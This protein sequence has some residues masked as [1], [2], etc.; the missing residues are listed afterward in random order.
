MS[1]SA[2]D[3][4]TPTQPDDTRQALL[5]KVLWDAHDMAEFL[6]LSVHC[7][8]RVVHA[9]PVGFPTALF[10]GGKWIWRSVEV[11]RWAEGEY[12]QPYTPPPPAAP[13]SLTM[14][15][16]GRPRRTI[17]VLANS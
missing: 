3:D 6:G 2:H 13:P 10:L 15:G 17:E 11:Q 14:R 4:H 12:I 5:K 16:R 7:I 1:T 8:R 9:P